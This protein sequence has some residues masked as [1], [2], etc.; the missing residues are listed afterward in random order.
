MSYEYSAILL[1]VIVA[2]AVVAYIVF[3][4]KMD[5]KM[6]AMADLAYQCA[7]E[8]LGIKDN[9][10]PPPVTRRKKGIS[11]GGGVTR[12]GEYRYSNLPL[13]GPILERIW[14]LDS[15][16]IIFRLTAHEMAHCR[17]RRAGLKKDHGPVEM[18]ER[19]ADEWAQRHATE[20]AAA[21]KKLGG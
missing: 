8:L 3:R 17:R 10:K 7:G 6:Q 15:V 11:Q 12:I 4:P 9:G 19:K 20:L 1:A 16:A 21:L 2:A 5:P 18:V 14:V 13:I